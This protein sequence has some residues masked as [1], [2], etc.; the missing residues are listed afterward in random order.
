VANDGEKALDIGDNPFEI[1]VTSAD[2]TQQN[3]YTITVNRM[4]EDYFFQWTSSANAS[5]RNSY[6]DFNGMRW[7]RDD[8]RLVEYIFITSNISGEY[9]FDFE[10]AGRT[11]S[12]TVTLVP[13]AIY[14]VQALLAVDVN[15][16]NTILVYNSSSPSASYLQ[17]LS[18]NTQTLNI[19][20]N[21]T[22]MYST[23]EFLNG[24][25]AGIVDIVFSLQSQSAID[26]F[27]APELSVYPNPVQD[28]L[29][30]NIPA[31]GKTEFLTVTDLSGR[32]VASRRIASIQEKINVSHLPAGIYLVRAGDYRGKFVKK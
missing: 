11:R 1:T 15:N 31:F 5:T 8:R 23:D 4:P 13:N 21:G 3:T 12:R 19:A 20:T 30:V 9:T 7:Y 14:L 27:D 26:E 2:G 28:E 6:H 18:A 22:T 29:R 25:L 16:G 17:Y 32:V 10:I 24:P